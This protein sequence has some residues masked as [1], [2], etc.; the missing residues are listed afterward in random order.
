[1]VEHGNNQHN[2]C[3]KLV[4]EIHTTLCPSINV[5]GPAAFSSSTGYIMESCTAIRG[6]MTMM[7]GH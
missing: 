2:T 4:Q 6:L 3:D 5:I 1:M 7:P